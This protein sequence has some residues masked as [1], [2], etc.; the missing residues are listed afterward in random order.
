M[1]NNNVD[2]TLRNDVQTE[3]LAEELALAVQSIL[4]KIIQREIERS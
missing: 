2:E 1:A 4:P 3:K